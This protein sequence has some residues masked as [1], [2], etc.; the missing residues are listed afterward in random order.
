MAVALITGSGGL[1]GSEAARYFAGLGLDVVGIDNDMRAAFFGP[2]ASTSWNVQR[3]SEDL[4]GRYSHHHADIRNRCGVEALF[5][6][7]ARDLRL[8]IHAAAQP[9]HDWA[10]RDPITDFEVNGTGTLNLL[11]AMRTWA[12]DA[13]FIF[14][15]T[16]KV[17]GD[18]PNSL[19][20]IEEKTRWEIDPA[21]PFAAGIPETLSIDQTLHSV[22]GA[23][24]VAADVMVQEFGRYFSLPT[25]CFRGGCLTGP[26]HSGTKLH[27]FLAYLVK[28]A[29]L[30]EP[31]TVLGYKGKQVRDNIHAADLVRA[32]AEFF[33]APRAGEVYNIGGGRY[34]NCSIL[35]AIESAQ[36]TVARELVYEYADANRTGDHVWWISD[37]SKFRGHYP[38][39]RPTYDVDA[40]IR[41]IYEQNADRW[42]REPAAQ[43]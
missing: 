30:G 39:W 40:I 3:L 15:S 2:E 32:F 25:G 36:R 7:Y 33:D 12:P 17:Y 11:V 37:C 24:K 23:S 43:A 27:G 29:A 5:R 20:L 4:K 8:V 22:F 10:A 41:E 1:V 42:E 38:K 21:H 31:Y 14:M 13:V 16:N 28:C 6:R 34:S 35:E 9:S 18:R 26:R 19:P